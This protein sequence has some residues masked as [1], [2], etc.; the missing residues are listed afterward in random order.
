MKVITRTVCLIL[1]LVALGSIE[2]VRADGTE[3]LGVPSI[4]IASG[5]GVAVGGTGMISQPG[6][7]NVDVPMGA[8]VKQV[9]L[10]WEGF[11]ADSSP[12]DSTILV[13]KGA[14]P[15]T[16]V[17]GTLIGG[18]TFFFSPAWASTFRAD[19]TSLGLVTAGANTLTVDG[20]SFSYANNG[21][22]VLVIYDDGTTAAQIQ[23]VDGSDLAFI[24]F[25]EPLKNTVAQTFNFPAW[26]VDRTAQLNMFFASVEGTLSGYGFRPTAIELTTGGTTTVLDNQL[27]SVSGQEWDTLSVPVNIPAGATSLT[28]QPFSRDDLGTGNLPA[29]FDWLA[30]SLA[31]PEPPTGPG[32]GTPGYWKNHPDAWPVDEIMIGATIY[33]KAQAIQLMQQSVQGDKRRTLFN[34]LVC[35]KLNVL[36]G[37]EDSCVAETIILADQWF[38]TYGSTPVKANSDA[39]KD[40]ELLYYI[41]DSYN[42]GLLCAPHRDS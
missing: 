14:I 27:D 4:A 23:I 11:M 19:I 8:T 33:T 30:A 12:A 1:G 17:A 15:A 36:I 18:A 7:I 22:G 37:N 3:T 35:A 29:S 21:A 24:N 42:N 20:L 6:T 31:L 25:D 26:P 13:S 38:V 28:V 34:A 39:W 32:T 9:L 41:L 40:G 2:Q 16:E 5:T 10:Y